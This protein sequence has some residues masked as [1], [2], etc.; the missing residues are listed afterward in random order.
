MPDFITEQEKGSLSKAEFCLNLKEKNNFDGLEEHDHRGA[1]R[2]K[3][4]PGFIDDVRVALVIWDKA[5]GIPMPPS[6]LLVTM[7][8]F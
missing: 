4:P 2:G 3:E 5:Q 1:R 8:F 6:G 7:V